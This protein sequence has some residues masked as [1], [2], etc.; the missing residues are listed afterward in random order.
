MDGL[1]ATEKSFDTREKKDYYGKVWMYVK[2]FYNKIIEISVGPSM[3][4][5][6]FKWTKNDHEE[7]V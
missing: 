2:I 3:L 6:I 1:P 7:K 5:I 4:C